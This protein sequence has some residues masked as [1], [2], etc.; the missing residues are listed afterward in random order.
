M[1]IADQLI[2]QAIIST[3]GGGGPLP[4]E[5]WGVT[6]FLGFFWLLFG[7][8]CSNELIRYQ[9]TVIKYIQQLFPDDFK[10]ISVLK[11]KRIGRI[12]PQLRKKY[13]QI[14]NLPII[15]HL[16]LLEL[17]FF[18]LA[19]IPVII[20]IPVSGILYTSGI[21]GITFEKSLHIG[22][23]IIY[24]FLTLIYVLL[25]RFLHSREKYGKGTFTP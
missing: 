7:F 5:F 11:V 17:S 21:I 1:S 18:S 13:P 10:N 2:V 25:A 8:V 4:K 23:G 14:S 20:I 16:N 15:K 6:I 24:I 9:T 22:T 19:T 3:F 12:V